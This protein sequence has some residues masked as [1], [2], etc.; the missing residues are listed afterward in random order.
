MALPFGPK[1]L[2]PNF[3]SKISQINNGYSLLSFILAK[4]RLVDIGLSCENIFAMSI[5]TAIT[6]CPFSIKK[7]FKM[8]I[9]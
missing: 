1:V 7:C 2:K 9:S 4:L 3:Q 6:A 5:V 8:S